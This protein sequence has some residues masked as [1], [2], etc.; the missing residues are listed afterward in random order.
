MEQHEKNTIY[1]HMSVLFYFRQISE[2]YR[3]V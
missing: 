3:Y 2:T 1:Q